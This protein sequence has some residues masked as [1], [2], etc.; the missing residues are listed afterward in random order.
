MKRKSK[1]FLFTLVIGALMLSLI[2]W[3][4]SSDV[5]ARRKKKKKKMAGEMAELVYTDNQYGFS[6]TFPEDWDI[7]VH[8]EKDPIRVV[9][10]KDNYAVPPAF[11]DAELYTTI[12]TVKII[13]DTTSLKLLDFLDSLKSP[14]FDSDQK[15]S[16]LLELKVLNGN[17][18]RPRVSRL[19]LE[20]GIKGRLF[21]T[22]LD[23]SINVQKPGSNTATP[24]QDQIK[25]DIAFFQEGNQLFILSAVCE[26]QYYEINKPLS[27]EVFNSFTL[28]DSK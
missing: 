5:Q 16:L 3:G 6:V 13:I 25:G 10:Q 7:R 12:P 9:A 8:E 26:S 4:G 19:R 28:T 27:D 14:T 17:F 18:G 1:N 22:S 24:V 15:N 11:K 21:R 20:N 23:Y 2:P